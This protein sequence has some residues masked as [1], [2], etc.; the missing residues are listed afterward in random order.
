MQH[1]NW[2]ARNHA[3]THS[4]NQSIIHSVN[5]SINRSTIQSINQSLI[6]KTDF[7]QLAIRESRASEKPI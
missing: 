5:Q 2:P 1:I 4:L 3:F 6:Q 7:K